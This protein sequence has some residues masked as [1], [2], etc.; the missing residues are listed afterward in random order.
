MQSFASAFADRMARIAASSL[1]HATHPTRSFFMIRRKSLR[2]RLLAIVLVGVV[3]LTIVNI[4]T[5]TWGLSRVRDRAVANNA[6][7]QLQ[8]AERTLQTLAHERADATYQRLNAVERLAIIARDHL[9]QAGAPEH[10][11]AALPL[12]TASD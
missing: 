3:V 1:H 12:Q 11:G 4:L 2:T 6:S 7:A 8:W 5:S 10:N 9:M